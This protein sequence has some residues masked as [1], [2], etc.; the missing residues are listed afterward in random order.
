MVFHEVIQYPRQIILQMAR[1][2]ILSHVLCF[3]ILFVGYP[4]GY[5]EGPKRSL[6]FGIGSYK[7]LF[8]FVRQA[9]GAKKELNFN[10]FKTNTSLSW[11]MFGSARRVYSYINFFFEVC[12][13][14]QYFKT[15]DFW[16]KMLLKFRVYGNRLQSMNTEKNDKIHLLSRE[17]PFCS[18]AQSSFSCHTTISM[19]NHYHSYNYYCCSS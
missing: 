8:G 12:F 11:R 10:S 7:R 19:L 3:I 5:L 17:C 16:Q 14:L 18:L 9:K 6:W 2:L 1:S 4:L 15:L 13:L